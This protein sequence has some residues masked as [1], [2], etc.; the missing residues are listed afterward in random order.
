MKYWSRRFA[1]IILLMA[2]MAALLSACAQ[3]PSQTSDQAEPPA[4]VAETE[5]AETQ[6]P[7]QTVEVAGTQPPAEPEATDVSAAAPAGEASNT[8][9]AAVT[10][11]IETLDPAWAYDVASASI[12]FNVYQ[13]LLFPT[14]EKTDEFVPLLASD[15]EVSDDGTT[16][17]FTI[18]DGVTFHEGQELTPEDVAYSFWRGMIQDRS[19][20][21][22]WILLQP[23]FGLNVH[24]FKDDVVAGQHNNDWQQAC[25]AL[26]QAI[27]FDPD[28]GTVTMQLKQPYEPLP[29]ILATFI[30]SIVSK[31]W[32]TEQNGWNGD[33]ATAEQYNDPAAEESELFDAMNG[34]G[35]FKFERWAPGEEIVL[36]RNDNYWQQEPLWEGGPSGPAD[37]TRVLFKVIEEWGTRFATF[38]AGDAD[39]ADVPRQFISQ[40]DPLVKET[41]TPTGEC[42]MTNPDGLLRLYKNLPQVASE[43][44]FFTQKVNTTGGNPMLGSG[45]LDGK[46]IPA[47]FFADPHVR[48]A[49]NY[50]F[51]WDTFV[52]QV[53]NGEA[54]QSLGPIIRGLPGYDP[55]Q[56]HYSFDLDT[57]AE[58]FKAAIAESADGQSLWD[59]GFLLQYTYP[60]GAEE[61]RTAGE[62][63]KEN[64]QK[65]NP[66]FQLTLAEEPWPAFLKDQTD[67]RMPIFPLGWQ[68]DFHD[69]HNWVTAFLASNGPYAG[70]Q[71][72]ASEL[73]SRMDTLITEGIQATDPQER[74]KIYRELQNLAY[75]NA[76]NLFLQ[77]PEARQYLQERVSGWYYNPTY[78]FPGLYFYPLS[79][80]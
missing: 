16:Y 78:P 25:N 41:C 22:Q 2:S 46:G 8:F 79:K 27:T 37:L 76:L 74:D 9:V 21:P 1:R 73:Q 50:C 65:V 17:T 64:L 47:D 61:W 40:V 59:T 35:P 3:P 57:C 18:R 43:A 20:G 62:I 19:G 54:V 7:A 69:P 45:Q 29:Q 63:L 15:W 49:F 56:Q 55:E 6:A 4:A 33:C 68:E 52:N 44:I 67:G 11:D 26:K 71:S 10:G 23:F 60:S 51:D 39:Y 75:E 30:T 24:N 14:K 5:V 77:Q 13:T 42:T 36:V 66:T 28:A 70:A 48:K 12:I 34:T 38:K 32:V 31:Q 72:F 80:E 58:E 53:F